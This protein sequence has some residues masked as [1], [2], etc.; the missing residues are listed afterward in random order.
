MVN[1]HK[2]NPSIPV[3]QYSSTF[4]IPI[5]LLPFVDRKLR[6]VCLS[7]LISFFC[8]SF[9]KDRM[10]VRTYVQPFPSSLIYPSTIH[11]CS[12]VCSYVRSQSVWVQHS[13]LR[14]RRATMTLTL[15][16]F[17]HIPLFYTFVSTP[18][19]QKRLHFLPLIKPF[20]VYIYTHTTLPLTWI[21]PVQYL[22]APFTSIHFCTTVLV[23]VYR[24]HSI[25]TSTFTFPL[26]AECTHSL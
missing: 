18:P 3:F 25:H 5:P 19:H 6:T 22:S 20:S 16:F 10:C 24:N 7:T 13:P 23:V 17:C 14:M 8:C 2:Y 12:T 11:Y 21:V 26:I 1:H 4:P 9:I 15:S